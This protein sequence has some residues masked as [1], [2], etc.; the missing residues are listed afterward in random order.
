M[1]KVLRTDNSRFEHLQ[2]FDF[3][4]HYLEIQDKEFGSLRMHYLDEGDT[5]APVIVCLHGQATWSYSYRNM[6]PVFVASGYRVIAP[7]FIG[8]GRS[9]KLQDD[10][11]Y[12]FA[13]HIQ[14]LTEA[15]TAL[16]ITDATGFFFDWGGYFGLPIAA[17]NSSIF[18]RLVLVNTTLP[19]AAGIINALWVAGWRK[20]ILKGPVFPIGEMVDKMTDTD[21]S[22]QERMALDAPFPDESYKAG[23]RSFPMLIPATTLNPATKA[24]RAAW[25]QLAGWTKP[26]VTFVSERLSKRGFSPKEFYRQIPGTAGQAH[27]TFAGAGFFIIE[28]CPELLAAST[29]RFIQSSTV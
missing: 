11:D 4:P 16:E 19:R 29:L 13:K 5:A 12:S 14:W 20:Y 28:D 7:D 25:A 23:P 2:D 17:A 3:E 10:S 8:F 18:S 26:A 27:Q 22:A 15:L 24:N 9:D 1:A 6:I 21:L